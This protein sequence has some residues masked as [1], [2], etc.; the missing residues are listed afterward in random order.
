M[1][2]FCGHAQELFYLGLI[3]TFLATAEVIRLAGIDQRDEG[4]AFAQRCLLAGVATVG[5]VAIDLLPTWY[6]SRLTI[7]NSQFAVEQVPG[8]S[9][10]N[11]VQ[12]LD[13]FALGHP[14]QSEGVSSSRFYWETVCHFGVIPLLLA[15][16]GAVCGLRS[17]RRPK[18]ADANDLR[19][20]TDLDVETVSRRSGQSALPAAQFALM[21]IFS[22]MFA[23]GAGSPLY[24]T[25]HRFVP[26]IATFR[27]P[28][29]MLFFASF[30][31]AIL[32]GIGVDVLRVSTPRN[33]PRLSRLL[34]GLA[35]VTASLL[36]C[37]W[38]NSTN[39][40]SRIAGPEGIPL[41]VSG[42]QN[43]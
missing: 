24:E 36:L 10:S 39:T 19:P 31:V 9:L 2:F 16:T 41:K 7:R 38:H 17:A 26:G 4:R 6:Y 28:S 5:L 43:L 35:L 32:A 30:A 25:F 3:L 23:F 12:L 42:A 22:M 8:L 18:V 27:I 21:W 11:L 33:S 37:S 34:A 40:F 20:R 13:P 1:C 15:M 29:R 14:A